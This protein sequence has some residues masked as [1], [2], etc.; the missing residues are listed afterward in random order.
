MKIKLFKLKENEEVVQFR[1]DEPLQIVI[2]AALE[3]KEVEED[4]KETIKSKSLPTNEVKSLAKPSNLKKQY[5]V[6]VNKKATP[7]KTHSIDVNNQRN[8]SKPVVKQILNLDF[9]IHPLI[10]SFEFLR[11]PEIILDPRGDQIYGDIKEAVE[12]RGTFPYYTPVGWQRFGLQTSVFGLEN[13]WLANDGNPNEW[14]VGYHGIISDR[15]FKK[16]L[17]D[18]NGMVQKYSPS[19]KPGMGQKFQ[20]D[21]NINK[22]SNSA[23]CGVG[24][25]FSNKVESAQIFSHLINVGP[26]LK[27]KVVLQCRINPLKVNQPI[28]APNIYIVQNNEDIRPYGILVRKYTT[29]VN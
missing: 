23:I 20:K 28:S 1:N 11:R 27:Y 26:N 3:E 4:S 21:K 6:D 13:D 9:E 25:Y 16:V 18:T 17:I 15:Y 5:S 7:M 10:Q 19:F 24:V 29:K 12:M 22:L 8:V 2:S 14:L